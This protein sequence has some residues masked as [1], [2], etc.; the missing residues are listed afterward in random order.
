MTE[1]MDEWVQLLLIKH[2][3]YV[4]CCAKSFI[5]NFSLNLPNDPIRIISFLLFRG[6]NWDSE[7]IKI[8]PKIIL[9]I[10]DGAGLS[11]WLLRLQSFCCF[12][13]TV[14]MK[15]VGG[16]GLGARSRGHKHWTHPWLEKVNLRHSL[17][18]RAALRPGTLLV[19]LGVHNCRW[20]GWPMVVSPCHISL[21]CPHVYFSHMVFKSIYLLVRTGRCREAVPE[22][23]YD[24]Q[25]WENAW[26]LEVS[27]EGC[28]FTE[29]QCHS[30]H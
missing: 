15:R 28:S 12:T 5:H 1:W 16:W 11:A 25:I 3:L 14:L 29:E 17:R 30:R 26:F 2:L 10:N 9:L 22:E 18:G 20:R 7:K 27:Q 19:R 6:G 13:T 21:I 23:L 4:R 8:L 24:W